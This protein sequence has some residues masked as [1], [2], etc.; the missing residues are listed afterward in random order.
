MPLTVTDQMGVCLRLL[1]SSIGVTLSYIYIPACNYLS[2]GYLYPLRT[3]EL[4]YCL[5]RVTPN[6]SYESDGAPVRVPMRVIV[7]VFLAAGVTEP[8]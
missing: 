3:C 2:I 7:D 5:R 4:C 1:S 6:R 8:P